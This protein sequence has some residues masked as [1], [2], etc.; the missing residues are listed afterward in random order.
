MQDVRCR[1]EAVRKRR[2]RCTRPTTDQPVFVRL[3]K[4][5]I[6]LID[7]R[8]RLLERQLPGITVNRSDMI[9]R[10]IIEGL[11]RKT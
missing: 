4:K 11:L 8:A 3:S 6:A 2:V 7:S 1:E 5:T 10:F 9:R